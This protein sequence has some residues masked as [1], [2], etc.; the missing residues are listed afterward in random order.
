MRR[1]GIIGVYLFA[2]AAWAQLLAPVA[3]AQMMSASDPFSVIC[4]TPSTDGG[5]A[6][7]GHHGSQA[8]Q[9]CV[10]CHAVLGGPLPDARPP[11]TALDYPVASRLRWRHAAVAPRP[12]RP[13]F[14][15]RP[16][17]PPALV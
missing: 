2:L 1:F 14:R 9:C 3:A 6:P 16:R 12:Y 15:H 13:A 5:G 10:L 11:Y 8:H 17:G 7:A 4:A